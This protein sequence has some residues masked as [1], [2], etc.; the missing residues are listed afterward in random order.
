MNKFL[1][2][3]N[4]LG[5]RFMTML[6]MFRGGL[7]IYGNDPNVLIGVVFRY[8]I[9]CRKVDCCFNFKYL[10]LVIILN[11][12]N[13]CILSEYMTD[14][15]WGLWNIWKILLI[16]YIPKPSNTTEYLFKLFFKYYKS[17]KIKYILFSACLIKLKYPK[18]ITL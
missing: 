15:I 17:S 9:L 2:A 4:I 5:L 18:D 11:L 1:P 3:T 12:W 14:F 16:P 6:E 7:L 8:C 13:L 10:F